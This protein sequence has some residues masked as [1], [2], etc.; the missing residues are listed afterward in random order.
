[1]RAAINAAIATTPELRAVFVAC[2][3]YLLDNG[4]DSLADPDTHRRDAER[5]SAPAHLMRQ[6]HHQPRARAS[7][8]MPKCDRAAVH[9][10]PLFVDLE[11]GVA[12]EHLRAERLVDFEQVDVADF[13]SRRAPALCASREPDPIP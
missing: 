1:M 12:R 2:R 8:R 5:G 4:R 13:Q 10:E 9:V 11:I 3:S 7:Q 6:R